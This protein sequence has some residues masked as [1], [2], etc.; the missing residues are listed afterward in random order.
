MAVL[1]INSRQIIY[2][3]VRASGVCACV[4]EYASTMSFYYFGN[5]FCSSFV[6]LNVKTYMK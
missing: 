3:F 2:T 5:S 1:T 6:A 4:R